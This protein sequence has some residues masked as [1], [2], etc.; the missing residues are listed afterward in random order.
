MHCIHCEIVFFTQRWTLPWHHQLHHWVSSLRGEEWHPSNG[1]Y[2]IATQIQTGNLRQ[3]IIYRYRLPQIYVVCTRYTEAII[4]REGK[5]PLQTQNTWWR[6]MEEATS[7]FCNYLSRYIALWPYNKQ[8]TNMLECYK[9]VINKN[10]KVMHAHVIW[11]KM[12]D[13]AEYILLQSMHSWS[14]GILEEMYYI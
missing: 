12:H 7:W 13:N 4:Y 9:I 3:T 5:R 11:H 1:A 14:S 2:N 10:M 6:C 8:N